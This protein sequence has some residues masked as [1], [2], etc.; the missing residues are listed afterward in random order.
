MKSLNID[1]KSKAIIITIIFVSAFF[2][3]FLRYVIFGS[4]QII[5]TP[6]F[7]I[8]KAVAFASIFY[9][10]MVLKNSKKDIQSAKIWFEIFSFSI[11]LHILLTLTLLPF[12]FY[13]KMMEGS[14]LNLSGNLTIIF[15]VLT[16]FSFYSKKILHSINLNFNKLT[17][18]LLSFHL[19]FL[20][21]QGWIEPSK[22]F[23]FMPPIT[24]ICFIIGLYL[25][26]MEL[27][28]KKSCGN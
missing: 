17:L 11:L 27:K 28:E 9:L 15:G 8:N 18:T 3:S 14:S 10:F 19:F 2:Y 22:W 6:T 4:V 21:W 1:T 23:G 26:F 13:K 24:L 12:G 5:H 7:I 16:C 20:G 25:L